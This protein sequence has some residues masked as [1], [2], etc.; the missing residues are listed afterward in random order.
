MKDLV[1][2]ILPKYNMSMDK[3][4]IITFS[5]G[6]LHH[7][8]RTLP[9]ML[10]Q[11][12]DELIVV[13]YACP[14]GTADWVENVH[15]YKAKT[16]RAEPEK[17]GPHINRAHAR[18]MG[19]VAAAGDYLI[20]FDSDT[21]VIDPNL[22]VK[23]VQQLKYDGVVFVSVGPPHKKG[24]GNCGVHRETFEAVRGFPENMTAGW[25]FEDNAFFMETQKLGEHVRIHEN[26]PTTQIH[27]KDDERLR[28]DPTGKKPKSVHLNRRRYARMERNNPLGWGQPTPGTKLERNTNGRT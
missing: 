21:F 13:D 26:C 1:I 14:D 23:M 16:V 9:F 7:L 18:N 15:R 25:G 8:K 6:R 19:A 5:K 3:I 20:F 10:E 2:A 11:R 4:S 17:V 24:K 22:T 12:H 27:H 28:F